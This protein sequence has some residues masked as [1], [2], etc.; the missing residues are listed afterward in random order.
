MGFPGLLSRRFRVLIRRSN[1]T[2]L[3]TAGK[4][5][6]SGQIGHGHE[7]A[8]EGA[9]FSVA[10]RHDCAGGL[11]SSLGIYDA[12]GGVVES[13]EQDSGEEEEQRISR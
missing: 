8:F 7:P 1:E 12:Y 11:R 3:F 10:C 13:E 5:R 9:T 6:S 2:L 4:C